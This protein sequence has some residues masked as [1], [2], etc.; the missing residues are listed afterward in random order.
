VEKEPRLT[1]HLSEIYS[2]DRSINPPESDHRRWNVVDKVI[3]SGA[4]GD[5]YPVFRKLL[6]GSSFDILHGIAYEFRTRRWKCQDCQVAN[7]N[8]II[9]FRTN[10]CPHCIGKHVISTNELVKNWGL[11]KDELSSIPFAVEHVYRP[12][13]PNK[14]V[15]L[16]NHVNPILRARYNLDMKVSLYRPLEMRAAIDKSLALIAVEG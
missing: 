16:I 13:K 9:P 14:R 15:N 4:L 7:G 2:P 10:F 12:F 1:L 11:E 8:W 5:E 6:Y 3:K